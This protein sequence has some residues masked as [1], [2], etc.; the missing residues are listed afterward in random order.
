MSNNSRIFNVTRRCSLSF[1]QAVRAIE[2][3]SAVWEV[4]GMS[5][6]D[7]SLADSIKARHEQARLREPLP[8]AEIPGLSFDPPA[9]GLVAHRQSSRLTWE[10]REFAMSATA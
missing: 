10:A 5:I 6:K 8:F 1:K 9:T 3:C 7:L 4:Y 2:N